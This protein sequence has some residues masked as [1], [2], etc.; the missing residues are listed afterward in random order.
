[1]PSDESEA[2]LGDEIHDD[3][4]DDDNLG[5]DGILGSPPLGAGGEEYAETGPS[6]VEAEHHGVEMA[7]RLGG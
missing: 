7:A 2:N 5:E 6:E 1:M 3:E 4:R